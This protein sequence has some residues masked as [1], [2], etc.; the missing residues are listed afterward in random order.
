MV[1]PTWTSKLESDLVP[2]MNLKTILI[3]PS[4]RNQ[5]IKKILFFFKRMIWI[6]INYKTKNMSASH[7][8][9]MVIS[10]YH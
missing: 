1:F 8:L 6:Y 4:K 2:K 5:S 3:M 9:L 10:Q 7:L